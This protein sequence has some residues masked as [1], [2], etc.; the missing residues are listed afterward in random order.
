MWPGVAG[1]ETLLVP[2]AAQQLR[3]DALGNV[4]LIRLDGHL[5][6][7]QSVKPRLFGLR[8]L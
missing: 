6:A 3:E 8:I 2:L 4:L 7:I 1:D 5:Q